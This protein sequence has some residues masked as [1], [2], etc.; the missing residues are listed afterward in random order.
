MLAYEEVTGGALTTALTP[1]NI[2]AM[3]VKYLEAE[4]VDMSALSPDQV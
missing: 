3:V 4:G 1:D 2:T